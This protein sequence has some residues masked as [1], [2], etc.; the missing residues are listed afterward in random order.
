MWDRPPPCVGNTEPQDSRIRAH[1]SGVR[2]EIGDAVEEGYRLK[3]LSFICWLCAHQG[4]PLS[5]WR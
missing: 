4:R 2:I 1:Y 3:L 5:R